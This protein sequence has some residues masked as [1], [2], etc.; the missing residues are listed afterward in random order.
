MKIAITGGAGRQA[1]AAIYDFVEDESVSEV[2]LIDIDF[3]KLKLRQEAMGSSKLKI[4]CI[5]ILNH[6]ALSEIL[7]PY[8]VC[9]N[10]SSHVFNIP[11][12]EACVS[13]KTNYTDL[14]GLF[15]WARK[16][17]KKNEDF[18][19]AEI[20]GIIGSGSAPGI[21]NV[22]AKYAV[23]RLDSVKSV[24]I[25]DGI[26]NNSSNIH[27]FI[28]PY[29]LNT[30][31]EEF[32]MNNFEFRDGSWVELPPFSG[33]EIVDFP[34]PFGRLTLHNMIHSE[35]ATMPIFFKD[36]GI[37]D[38]SFKLALPNLF[39]ERLRFLVKIGLTS[40][41][42]INV[43]DVKIIPRDIICTLIEGSDANKSKK[44][45]SDYDDHKILRVIVNGE[46][47]RKE[48]THIVECMIHP[49]KKWNMPM[50]PFS[51]GFPAA[52]TTKLLG[53]GEIKEKGFYSGEA[54]IDPPTYFRNLAKRN[55]IVISK[56]IQYA[57]D[58]I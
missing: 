21:V 20:T 12:M 6:N 1:L 53:S 58:Q 8:N 10:C 51:V 19:R 24:R 16:Q 50:G 42:P 46:K 17:L 55:I 33:K 26:I 25:Q 52:I 13:A 31:I 14:G 9:L 15:H 43:G 28:P 30:L 32:T 38:V 7:K 11:V 44:N 18:V 5:D 45:I 27:E 22:M 39:S 40:N 35:V 57:Y 49:Y 36:K 48:Q 23:D 4:Q 34:Q 56:V 54:I 2:L 37:K 47:K 3:D 29:S 41:E